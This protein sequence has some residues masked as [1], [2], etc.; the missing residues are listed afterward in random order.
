MSEHLPTTFTILC[1]CALISFLIVIISYNFAAT[2]FI[3]WR[4]QSD[5]N[6]TGLA[7]YPALVLAPLAV[8]LAFDW[9]HLNLI[10]PIEMLATRLELIWAALPPSIVL[11]LASGLAPNL[12]QNVKNRYRHWMH[13]PFARVALAY[14][15]T[16]HQALRKIVIC[17]SIIA[18]WTAALP[19]I[20][21]ELIVVEAIFNAPGLGLAAWQAARQQDTTT[22]LEA[23]ISLCCSYAA[24][25]L[26][27]RIINRRIGRLLESYG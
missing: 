26:L 15:H 17:E 13:Q 19:W 10:F 14:G 25:A 22:L 7:L 5:S 21:S 2:R 20:F 24:L 8:A 9:F 23:L 18:A 1:W 11:V 12:T 6:L 27:S 16:P 4:S 3:H